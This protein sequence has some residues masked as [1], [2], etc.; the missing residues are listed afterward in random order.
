VDNTDSTGVT[1]VGT[2]VASTFAP[3]FNGSNYL[4]D[5]NTGKGTKS[6]RFTPNLPTSGTYEV[7]AWWAASTDRATAVPFDITSVSGTTTVPVNQRLNGY[8]W[9]SLGTYT[10]NAG[11]GGSVLIRTTGT[12]DGY[13]MADAVRFVKQ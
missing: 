12:T 1:L 4:H 3:P 9:R 10:F 11:T 2:W 13:V 6:I 5:G 8:Q 7:F